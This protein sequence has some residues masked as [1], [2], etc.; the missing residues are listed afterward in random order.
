[1]NGKA[2]FISEHRYWYTCG[3]GFELRGDD[4]VECD[5]STGQWS[6]VP[7]CE[8]ND[9]VTETPS[10]DTVISENVTE[11]CAP[12]CETNDS[13]TETPSYET[14]LSENATE[15]IAMNETFMNETEILENTTEKFDVRREEGK[16]EVSGAAGLNSSHQLHSMWMA[17]CL[18]CLLLFV[19]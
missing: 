17:L 6:A 12:T 13:V 9:S 2:K 5:A 14:V 7:T 19:F 3:E 10:F 1:V 11:L 18:F 4:Y 8:R 15:V 16:V